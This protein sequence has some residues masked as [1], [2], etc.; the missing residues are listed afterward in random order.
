M[1]L[2]LS[3]LYGAIRAR[4]DPA[5]AAKENGGWKAPESFTRK[6]TKYLLRPADLLRVK[7]MIIRHLPVL[8]FL[9][10]EKHNE[11][12]KPLVSLDEDKA[13]REAS[14]SSLITSVY[15]DNYTH[16]VQSRCIALCVFVLIESLR[17]RTSRAWIARRARRCFAFVGTTAT[18]RPRPACDRSSLSA[19][20]VRPS[21]SLLIC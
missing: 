20:N 2:K 18:S 14:D 17:S 11:R 6:T 15:C 19:N 3:L 21:L 7:T 8:I 9:K 10:P 13:A 5:A 16:D 4:R 1:L 12:N